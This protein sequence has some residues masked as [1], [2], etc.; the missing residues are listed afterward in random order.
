MKVLLK[1]FSISM[2]YTS[3]GWTGTVTHAFTCTCHYLNN[4]FLSPQEHPGICKSCEIC[5][6]FLYCFLCFSHFNL[7]LLSDVDPSSTLM[8]SMN[9]I[10]KIMYNGQ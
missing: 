4:L 7:D 10:I 5:S 1:E 8:R 3:N 6:N 2:F 9:N